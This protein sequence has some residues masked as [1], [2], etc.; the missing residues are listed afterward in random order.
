MFEGSSSD[1][2]KGDGSG[3]QDL[4]DG[5]AKGKSLLD[6]IA[7]EMPSS[8]DLEGTEEVYDTNN[9]A[10]VKT[11]GTLSHAEYKQLLSRVKTGTL[12]VGAKV[13]T[14]AV[15]KGAKGAKAEQTPGADTVQRGV[16]GVGMTPLTHRRLH[17][18]KKAGW[19]RQN[20]ETTATT[21]PA[22]PATPVKTPGLHPT[23]VMAPLVAVLKVFFSQQGLFKG[24]DGGIGSYRLYVLVS[25]FLDAR[26]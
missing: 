15:A 1:A 6:P 17:E 20:A 26:Q 16:G 10:V 21:T 23:S 9:F 2:S 5:L 7:G 13:E 24:G 25:A 4:S 14:G 19:K 3:N 12:R 18:L 22:V 11:L 8:L